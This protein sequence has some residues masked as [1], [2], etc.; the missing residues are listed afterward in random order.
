[1]SMFYLVKILQYVKM[2]PELSFLD[3]CIKSAL[4][5]NIHCITWKDLFRNLERTELWV[6]WVS[7]LW[8]GE[9]V[10]LGFS[11][12]IKVILDWIMRKINMCKLPHCSVKTHQSVTQ[13]CLVEWKGCYQE[14]RRLLDGLQWFHKPKAL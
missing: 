1:M 7:K 11:R 2:C 3:F 9:H 13:Y 6:T 10:N 4:Q 8:T 5:Y 14:G 12:E